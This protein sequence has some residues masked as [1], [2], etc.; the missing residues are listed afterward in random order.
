MYPVKLSI[1][2]K[3][4]TKTFQIKNNNSKNKTKGIQQ[5]QIYPAINV[6]INFKRSYLGRMKVI[7]VRNTYLRRERKHAIEAINEI[8]FFNTSIKI[9]KEKGLTSPLSLFNHYQ[10]TI[11]T[12]TLFPETSCLNE[13]CSQLFGQ[14][15]VRVLQLI[16][17]PCEFE[18]KL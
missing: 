17:I 11:L 8:R 6:K 13:I 12:K 18:I 10:D 3:G 1:K 14:S 16:M 9:E 5:Q 15:M 4:K 2:C 7:Q